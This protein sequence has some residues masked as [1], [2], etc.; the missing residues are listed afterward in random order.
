VEWND[1]HLVLTPLL[2]RKCP[3]GPLD[4][5]HCSLLEWLPREQTLITAAMS[6]I[7]NKNGYERKDIKVESV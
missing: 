4:E 2:F 1:Q 3:R 6:N 5:G 7:K